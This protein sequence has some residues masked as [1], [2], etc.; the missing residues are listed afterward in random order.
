MLDGCRNL[1]GL[2][3]ELKAIAAASKGKAEL[4]IN[5]TPVGNDFDPNL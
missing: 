5:L 1:R 4:G 2:L 3:E